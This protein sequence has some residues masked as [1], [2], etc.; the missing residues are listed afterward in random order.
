VVIVKVRIKNKNKRRWRKFI[1]EI[2]NLSDEELAKAIS[3]VSPDLKEIELKFTKGPETC[4][5]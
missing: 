5:L 3:Y 4:K 1:S 2:E